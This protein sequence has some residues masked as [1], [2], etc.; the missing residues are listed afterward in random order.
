MKTHELDR[1]HE[2]LAR[3]LQIPGDRLDVRNGH[4]N[5]STWSG[6]IETLVDP[7]YLD[8]MVAAICADNMARYF[9]G[10][11]GVKDA[12]DFGWSTD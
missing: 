10:V 5:R 9:P 8:E 12:W 7:K 4:L 11:A 2:Q 3:F 6:R 1:S